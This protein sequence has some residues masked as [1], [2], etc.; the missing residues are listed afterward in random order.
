MKNRIGFIPRNAPIQPDY[1][2]NCFN[3]WCAVF[4]TKN[5]KEYHIQLN[6]VCGDMEWEGANDVDIL[7]QT[8]THRVQIR[9]PIKTLKEACEEMKKII[10]REDS[11]T[12]KEDTP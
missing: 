12:V 10:D 1:Y 5:D 11:Q 8:K 3:M 6:H 2:K 9:Q 4:L 7:L